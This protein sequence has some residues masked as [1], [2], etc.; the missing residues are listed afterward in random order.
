M[1][2]DEFL[3]DP[4]ARRRAAAH[5]L[6]EVAERADRAAEMGRMDEIYAQLTGSAADGAGR[7]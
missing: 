6:A 4:A 2:L 5:N 7:G 1:A 3:G